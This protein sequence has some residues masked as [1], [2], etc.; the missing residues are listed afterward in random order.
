MYTKVPIIA[1]IYGLSIC[2][3]QLVSHISTTERDMSL[4]HSSVHDPDEPGETCISSTPTPSH[5]AVA[6]APPS[7]IQ[8][9]DDRILT[10]D[11]DGPDD[12]ENPRKFV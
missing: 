10:V 9:S 1:Y 12:P 2:E 5:L 4:N 8:A 11:W 6:L 3:S 7:S